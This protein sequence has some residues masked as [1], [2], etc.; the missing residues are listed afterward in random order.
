MEHSSEWWGRNKRDNAATFLDRRRSTDLVAAP[1]LSG[2]T[3][4]LRPISIIIPLFSIARNRHRSTLSCPHRVRH[5]LSGTVQFDSITSAVCVLL[6]ALI[7]LRKRKDWFNHF[8][9][10]LR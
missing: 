6:S 3:Q 9:F 10:S 4:W 1:S 8:R 7:T 5:Q 2:R